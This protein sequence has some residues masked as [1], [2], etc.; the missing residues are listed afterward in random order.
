MNYGSNLGDLSGFDNLGICVSEYI[1]CLHCKPCIV[2]SIKHGILCAG[3]RYKS[4]HLTE[5]MYGVD[6]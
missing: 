4:L 2:K 5:V 6:M 3:I 1:V